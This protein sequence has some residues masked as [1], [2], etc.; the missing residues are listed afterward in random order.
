M[1]YWWWKFWLDYA[2]LQ[3]PVRREVIY[4]NFKRGEIIR[5]QAVAHK[6]GASA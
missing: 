2:A 6:C 3:F 4:M 1:W 5:V